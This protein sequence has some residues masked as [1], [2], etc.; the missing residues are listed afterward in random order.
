MIYIR[1]TYMI[2]NAV[3]ILSFLFAAIVTPVWI[4]PGY[5]FWTAFCIFLMMAASYSFSRRF[6][7]WGREG[8]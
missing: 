4:T 8:R 1:V 2:L 6:D 5:Y 7:Q 3:L